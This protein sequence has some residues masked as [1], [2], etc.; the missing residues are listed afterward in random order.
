MF[1]RSAGLILV[2]AAP[3]LG[4]SAE[5]HCAKLNP[6]L[7]FRDATDGMTLIYHLADLRDVSAAWIE[8][9]DRPKRLYRTQIPL[10]TDGQV[11]WQPDDPYP[12]TPEALSL[13]IYDAELPE[14]CIDNPC[15]G[16]SF[17]HNVSEVAVG[18][19]AG[20]S[21]GTAHLN[22]PPIRLPEGSDLTDVV[23][24][25]EDLPTDMKVL[26]VER[27]E[28]QE[29]T[30]WTFREYLN[31]EA[32][33]LR[34]MKVSIPSAYLLKPTVL[35]LI[36][37]D[38]S[39]E[40]DAA[41]LSKLLPEQEIFVASK[42]SPVINSLE[43][44]SIRADTVQTNDVP[45]TLRGSGFTKESRAVFGTESAVEMGLDGGDADFVSSQEL[46][47]QILSSLVTF[48][49]FASNEPIRVWVT[50]DDAL[51]ISEPREIEVVP[52]QSMKAAPKPAAINSVNPFPIPLM[53]AQSPQYEVV[54][55]D[56][57][58]FRADDRVVAVLEIG[59]PFEGIRLKTEFVSE[60]RLRAWLPR[61]LWRKHQLSYRLLLQTA[62]GV[63]SKEVFDDEQ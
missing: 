2:L 27:D 15:A 43:P 61:E 59:R 63:C 8:V 50:D 12:T 28:T 36:A 11:L 52:T 18:D 17:G 39:F 44:S 55:I 60:T 35:G 22:G 53:D 42:A 49:P 31:T 19:S 10:K 30:R 62:A 47:A 32:I 37:Q 33:D 34:H 51:K 1:R 38:A 25:G 56:G 4:Q 14:F 9:W 23:A 6:K 21:L 20:E 45:V 16:P 58:N 29:Q 13:A 26:L 41:G 24:T 54:E 46:R 48:G 40:M 5:N 3:L 57:E 7:D